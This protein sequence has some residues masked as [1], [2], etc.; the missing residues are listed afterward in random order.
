[1][2]KSDEET[3]PGWLRD[4]IDWFQKQEHGWEVSNT[5]YALSILGDYD[6]EAQLI[7]IRGVL[8]RNRE[9][10]AE[11]AES[12]R[13][14]D[15]RIRN[16]SGNDDEYQMHME[17]HW[18]DTLHGTVFQDAAHSMSAVGML[19]PFTES[20]VALTFSG[21]RTIWIEDG[22]SMENTVRGSS[23][24]RKFWDTQWTCDGNEWKKSGH[25]RGARQLSDVLGLSPYVTIE[26]FAMHGALT[27]YRNR[28][29]HNGFEWPVAE[30]LRFGEL[31]LSEGWPSGWFKKSTTG[32]DPWIYYM[33]DE[34]IAYCI[35]MVER[36]LDGVGSYLKDSRG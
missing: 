3:V 13:E 17:N 22:R 8:R 15:A 7:A 10:E 5:D 30:R 14:L 24:Y 2:S 19:A 33:S 29:F 18:V 28:M 11:V 23:S 27:A 9:A 4:G 16:Y 21:L 32:G 31:L 12:I 25:V 35:Q 34:F 1:M 36:F 6:L 26:F 20:L